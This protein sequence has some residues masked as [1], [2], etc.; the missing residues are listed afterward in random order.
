MSTVRILFFLFKI[1]AMGL[2]FVFF[3]LFFL[4]I[5]ATIRLLHNLMVTEGCYQRRCYCRINGMDF[6]NGT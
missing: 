4:F 5:G 2:Y 1:N 3:S 6:Y